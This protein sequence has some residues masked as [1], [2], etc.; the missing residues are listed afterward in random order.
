MCQTR[1]TVD[2]RPVVVGVGL[3]GVEWSPK[4]VRHPSRRHRR[5]PNPSPSPSPGRTI[6]RSSRRSRR[7]PLRRAHALIVGVVAV[8]RGVRTPD[9]GQVAVTQSVAIHVRAGVARDCRTPSLCRERSGPRSS[10]SGRLSAA[11]ADTV[12][13]R[14]PSRHRC[15]IER[16]A[17]AIVAAVAVRVHRAGVAAVAV[18]VL[19]RDR[20]VRTPDIGQVAAPPRTPSPSTSVSHGVTRVTD[21]VA[22]RIGLIGVEGHRAVVTRVADTVAIRIRPITGRIERPA[23]AIVAAVSVRSRRTASG[24]VVVTIRRRHSGHPALLRPP[25]RRSRHR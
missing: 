24:V 21:T 15:R 10:R 18:V 12:A 22:V 20:G 11:S 13:I 16:P 7:R 17:G 5:Y 19:V 6:R 9:I 14:H 1:V 3:I 2:I 25:C 23:G 8:G 4:S